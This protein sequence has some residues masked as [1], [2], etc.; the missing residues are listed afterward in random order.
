MT[1]LIFSIGFLI[2]VTL[3]TKFLVDVAMYELSK[4]KPKDEE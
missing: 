3:V 1:V 4:R 2:A